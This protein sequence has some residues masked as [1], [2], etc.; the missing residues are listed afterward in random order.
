M[1]APRTPPAAAPIRG[2][3]WGHF[4]RV[5]PVAGGCHVP[6]LVPCPSRSPCATVAPVGPVLTPQGGWWQRGRYLRRSPSC[7]WGAR[8]ALAINVWS[9][10]MAGIWGRVRV[11]LKRTAGV[12]GRIPAFFNPLIPL[13]Q[14]STATAPQGTELC[15]PTGGISSPKPPKRWRKR[16][17]PRGEEPSPP[18]KKPTPVTFHITRLPAQKSKGERKLKGHRLGQVKIKSSSSSPPLPPK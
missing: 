3:P 2:D 6:A 5:P 12:L 11:L 9:R 7:I 4:G 13:V 18:K 15:I 14:L 16:W 17:G 1:P 8:W 10:G